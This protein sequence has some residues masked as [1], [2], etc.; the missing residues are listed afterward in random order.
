MEDEF[1]QLYERNFAPPNVVKLSECDF[2]SNVTIPILDDPITPEEVQQQI[3]RIKPDK[4][5]GPDGIPSGTMKMLPAQWI[6]IFTTL[7]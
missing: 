6:L 3:K 1:Q 4:A 7:F 2:N 5:C